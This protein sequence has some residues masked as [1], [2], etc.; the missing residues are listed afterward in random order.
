MSVAHTNTRVALGL[1]LLRSMVR[2]RSF[3]EA[4]R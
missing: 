3:E 2:I 4:A 1:E